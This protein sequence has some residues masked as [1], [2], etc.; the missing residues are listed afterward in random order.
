MEA[1]ERPSPT[2][3]VSGLLVLVSPALRAFANAAKALDPAGEEGWARPP[4]VRTLDVFCDVWDKH[5]IRLSRLKALADQGRRRA[6]LLWAL[7]LGELRASATAL[8]AAT[9]SYVG[10]AWRVDP[11]MGTA[12]HEVE[13]GGALWAA[14]VLAN[15]GGQI[16]TRALAAPLLLGH[17]GLWGQS[18]P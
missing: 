17:A 7:T 16:L 13:C 5:G 11:A 9:L 1:K 12:D 6:P 2:W 10:K 15:N 14:L 18:G 3:S 4:Q 8:P